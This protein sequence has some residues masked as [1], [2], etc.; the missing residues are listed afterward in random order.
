[1]DTCLQRGDAILAIQPKDAAGLL[2]TAL[3]AKNTSFY[4]APAVSIAAALN[5]A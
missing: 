3:R 2:A 5:I 4:M 1:M